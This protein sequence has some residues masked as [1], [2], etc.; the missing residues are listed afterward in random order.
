M[1][2]ALPSALVWLVQA[3]EDRGNAA[4][5]VEELAALTEHALERSAR[6]TSAALVP[7]LYLVVGVC[8][9]LLVYSVL[10]PIFSAGGS[11]VDWI[12]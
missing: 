9:L 10:E 12:G 5:G 11:V 8:V 7:G 4:E 1:C 3:A 2:D 6:R